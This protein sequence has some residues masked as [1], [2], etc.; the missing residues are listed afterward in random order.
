MTAW[1]TAGQTL[2]GS[3]F[4]AETSRARPAFID[5]NTILITMMRAGLFG[6]GRVKSCVAI[7]VPVLCLL[8][9]KIPW[10]FWTSICFCAHS[11]T[12]VRVPGEGATDMSSSSAVCDNPKTLHQ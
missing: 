10:P 7:R 5:G 2:R 11:A 1:S 9:G 6:L 12:E 4:P 3:N 8:V